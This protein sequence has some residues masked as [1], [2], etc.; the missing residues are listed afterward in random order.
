MK[1]FKEYY[2]DCL[3]DPSK[4]SNLYEFKLEITNPLN[5]N[6]FLQFPEDYLD[7]IDRVHKKFA[8]LLDDPKN[9]AIHRD[10][11]IDFG[12][13]LKDILDFEELNEL[14]EIILPQIEN[15]IYGCNIFLEG[16]YCYRNVFRDAPL[17][18]S[19]LWHYDND[20]KEYLKVMIYLTDV[21]SS[22]GPMG[23]ILNDS[24]EAIKM[25]TSKVDY[26]NWHTKN[27]RVNPKNI[28]NSNPFLITGPRG[29]VS[30][31]DSNIV[32]KAMV[33]EKEKFRD[34]IVFYV[35]PSKDSERPYVNP[36]YC[37]SWDCAHTHCNPEH[38]EVAK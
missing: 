26:K 11:K 37:Q 27:S 38:R 21:S 25:E 32:H 31:F 33:P 36:K 10:P 12:I 5:K 23:V 16:V 14:A 19:W 35:K 30:I 15:K 6:G 1:T 9:L 4:S 2:F 22:D 28:L 13:R 7:I 34:V 29:T 18:S 3:N 24:G 20:P 8:L 17:R